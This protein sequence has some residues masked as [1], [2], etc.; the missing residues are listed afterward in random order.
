MRR[1]YADTQVGQ[2]HYREAGEGPPVL[3]LHQTSSSSVNF[4]R[5]LPILAERHRAIAMDTPGFGQS[6]PPAGPPGDMRHYAAAAVGLLDALGLD[7][8]HVVGFHTGASIAIEVAAQHG[9]RVD[10]LVLSGILTVET[11]AE[12][13]SWIAK[14]MRPFELDGR[15]DYVDAVIKPWV[16]YYA[17]EDD[18]EQY[19]REL[20][21][22][23]QAAPSWWW[24]Q[25]AVLRYEGRDAMRR[26]TRPTLIV[27]ATEDPVYAE[28][29]AVRD[30]VPGAAYVEI[31]GDT[32]A[33]VNYPAEF[34][35]AV[36]GFLAGG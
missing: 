21:A 35:A 29:L 5:V 34:A 30:H 19:H 6:D 22:C 14:I 33:L 7:R 25:D 23:L 15:G 20:I 3:L 24:A 28:T 26:I 18:A 1:G 17:L 4:E 2:I 11:E 31:P 12:R 9:D 16:R 36:L 27:N 8:V 10:R 13:E 32:G